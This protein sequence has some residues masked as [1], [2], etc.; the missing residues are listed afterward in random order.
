MIKK[1]KGLEVKIGLF[2]SIGLV[3]LIVAIWMLGSTHELFTRK[4]TY[5]LSV[6]SAEGLA[7]G[8]PVMIAGVRSGSV[9]DIMLEPR[10]R[11]VKIKMDISGHYAESIRQD[12]VAHVTSHG[13]LGDKVIS[14]SAGDPA[15]PRLS[16]G[17]IIPASAASTFGSVFGAKGEHIMERIDEVTSHLDELLAALTKDGKTDLLMNNLVAASGA[18]TTS[19]TL[20][21]DQLRGIKLKEAI[22]NLNSILGKADHGNGTVS[23]LINDPQ[24]YDDAKALIGETNHNRIMRNLVRK[25]IEDGQKREAENKEQA[26]SAASD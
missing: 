3:L 9:E 26:G 6:P 10:E 8:A 7:S 25:S 1:T 11:R 18:I 20:L 16:P 4:Q 2:A 23:G 15:L 21:N 24:I 13:V 14:I 17:S 12:S 19:A 5:Y 22:D